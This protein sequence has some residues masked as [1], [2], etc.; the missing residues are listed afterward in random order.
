MILT[1]LIVSITVVGSF[2]FYCVIRYLDSILS[3]KRI[4]T[5]KNRIESTKQ[6]TH[7][8]ITKKIDKTRSFMFKRSI[9]SKIELREIEHP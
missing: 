9:F 3:R 2:T 5:E 6:V 1:V 8:K 4:S 7:N